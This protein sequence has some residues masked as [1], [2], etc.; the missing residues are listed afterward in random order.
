MAR[1]VVVKLRRECRVMLGRMAVWMRPRI[2]IVYRTLMAHQGNAFLGLWTLAVAY[3]RT[4]AVLLLETFHG[5]TL[6]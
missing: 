3:L 1:R 4:D 2:F 5:R 6:L